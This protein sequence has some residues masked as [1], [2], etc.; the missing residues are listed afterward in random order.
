MFLLCSMIHTQPI[1]AAADTAPPDPSA[2]RAV[3]H[4]RV[5]EELAEI[6][7]E[8]ARSVR[9]QALEPGVAPVQGD[10]GLAFSRISRAVRQTIALEARID[11]DQLAWAAKR[12]VERTA[13]RAEDAER[14]AEAEEHRIDA[15]GAKVQRV[16]EQ[17]IQA[18]AADADEAERLLDGMCE[19]LDDC[20]FCDDLADRP[21]GEIVARICRDLGLTP[22]WSRWAQEGWAV[23]EA[24]DGAP[25][26]PYALGRSDRPLGDNDGGGA[27]KVRPS[28]RPERASSG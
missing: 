2:E 5:L 10:L 22:D 6:G 15:R 28:R 9:R 19:R 21:I 4:M 18:E 1:T 27:V 3:R 12:A 7:M 17:A 20:E 26:S 25:G 13:R 23:E 14:Q 16:I 24:R 8:L 11:A